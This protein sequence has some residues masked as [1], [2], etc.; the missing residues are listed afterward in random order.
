VLFIFN[1]CPNIKRMA[2][3]QQFLGPLW[4]AQP[5]EK[6]ERIAQI[7][8]LHFLVPPCLSS[9]DEHNLN[10]QTYSPARTPSLLSCII[11]CFLPMQIRLAR[12]GC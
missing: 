10:T 1:Q 11:E 6:R 8:Y 5:T 2:G 9:N 12:L 7:R 3:P 4:F